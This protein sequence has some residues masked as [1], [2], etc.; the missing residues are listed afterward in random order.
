MA[1]VHHLCRPP[2]TMGN[3]TNAPRGRNH[4]TMI[5][6]MSAPPG[7]RTQSI[8]IFS[9]VRVNIHFL[10]TLQCELSLY[11]WYLSNHTNSHKADVLIKL[12]FIAI[13]SSIFR[14]V[15]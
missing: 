8:S 11:A 2:C 13:G 1:A 7:R 9:L 14:T 3:G 12:I 4:C 6:G 10:F 5:Y 15:K